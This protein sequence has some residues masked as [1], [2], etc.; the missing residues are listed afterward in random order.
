MPHLGTSANNNNKNTSNYSVFG[1]FNDTL[2][3]DFRE[4]SSGDRPIAY[5][6]NLSVTGCSMSTMMMAQQYSG[7]PAGIQQHPGVPPGHPM[8]PGH[9]Q[10]PGQPGGGQPGA[11]GMGQQ[12]HPGVS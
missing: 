11:P 10:H 6:V 12:M 8:A 5:G 1:G 9:P 3:Q 7:H 2:W 4:H